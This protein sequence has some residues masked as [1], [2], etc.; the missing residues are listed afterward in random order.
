MLLLLLNVVR[1]DGHT[2]HVSHS[3]MST[4]CSLFLS[5]AGKALT[6]LL[7]KV[8]PPPLPTSRAFE[9]RETPLYLN[10]TFLSTFTLST[11]FNLEELWTTMNRFSC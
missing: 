2:P 4:P 7:D 8:L 10:E 9:L 3:R 5:T 1:T 11:N 6:S